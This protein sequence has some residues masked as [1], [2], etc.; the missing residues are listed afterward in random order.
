MKRIPSVLFFSFAIL[1]AV[2]FSRGPAHAHDH[3]DFASRVG[4]AV[5]SAAAGSTPASPSGVSGQ[6]EMKFR[7]AYTADHL[8]E[9]GVKVLLSAHG[10]FAVDRLK[11]SVMCR[12]SLNRLLIGVAVS[13]KSVLADIARRSPLGATL[14]TTTPA[15]PSGSASCPIGCRGCAICRHA[16]LC[17]RPLGNRRGLGSKTISS[18]L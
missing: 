4:M 16:I 7:V 18:E 14:P 8:P 12:K 3:R 6:G 10:G 9:G 11:S 17:R 15:M 2:G 1:L 13:M 5:G